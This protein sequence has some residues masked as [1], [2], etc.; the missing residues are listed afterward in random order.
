MVWLDIPRGP[1]RE[2]VIGHEGERG[3]ANL[4]RQL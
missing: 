3:E 2:A 1:G 4:A